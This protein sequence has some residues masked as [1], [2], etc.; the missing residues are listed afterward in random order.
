MEEMAGTVRIGSFK[1]LD[2]E[3]L[4]SKFLKLPI[5]TVPAISSIRNS[6]P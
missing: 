1:K 6:L 2:S 3:I 5:R 4:L